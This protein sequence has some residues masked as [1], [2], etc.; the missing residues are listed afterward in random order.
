MFKGFNIIF[1]SSARSST[2]T[3]MV[4]DHKN[5]DAGAPP[6]RVSRKTLTEDFYSTFSSPLAWILVLALVITWS[7][8]FIIMFDLVDYK[9]ISGTRRAAF[10]FLLKNCETSLLFGAIMWKMSE[11][12]VSSS[13]EMMVHLQNQH[14]CSMSLKTSTPE[15]P[16]KGITTVHICSLSFQLHFSLCRR[17][18]TRENAQWHRHKS[19][20][21]AIFVAHKTDFFKVVLTKYVFELEESF[22]LSCADTTC[23]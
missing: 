7:C 10:S 14:R 3:T 18:M 22:S 15:R 6:M 8:V 21:A 17:M 1:W 20:H 23:S 9:T 5:G 2:T 13:G 19:K 4:I 11:Q 16:V 12:H